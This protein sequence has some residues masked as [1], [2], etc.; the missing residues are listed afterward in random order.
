MN[1]PTY[2]SCERG[3]TLTATATELK[4][5][6][7]IDTDSFLPP[8]LRLPGRR[9]TT[10][11]QVGES[12]VTENTALFDNTKTSEASGPTGSSEASGP[13][14][15][16]E[17]TGASGSTGSSEASGPTGSSETAGASGST[18]SSEA[19]GSTGSS[20]PT[21]ERRRHCSILPPALRLPGRR[22]TAGAQV[23]V[24]VT[25]GEETDKSRAVIAPGE[26]TV[27]NR[28]SYTY[29]T[30]STATENSASGSTGSSEVFWINW[31][32]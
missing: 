11:A 4:K 26:K 32:L 5:G 7:V 10:G 25:E 8:A 29:S 20:E 14:G 1:T 27:F 19:S 3:T 13:T 9:N 6:D 16:S 15:S 17:T 31:V 22:N 28:E 12:I 23:G 2:W 21:E 18:G 30:E 24:A